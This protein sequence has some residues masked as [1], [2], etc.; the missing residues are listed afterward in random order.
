MKNINSIKIII[1]ILFS[2]LLG[3]ETPT[4]SQSNPEIYGEWLLKIISGGIAGKIDTLNISTDKYVLS[5][6]DNLATYSYNDKLLWTSAFNITK[7][8]S[9]YSS[10]SLFFIFYSNDIQPDVILYLSKD[11]LILGDNAYDGYAR[12]FTKVNK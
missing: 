4:E 1:L 3:C 6:Y 5:F 10:D 9:I 11:S 7:G 2:F 12:L 8:K